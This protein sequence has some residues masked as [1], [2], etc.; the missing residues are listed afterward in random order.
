VEKVCTVPYA[1]RKHIIYMTIIKH[2]QE[3]IEIPLN[4]GDT[5]KFGKFKN[6]S[7]IYKSHYINDKGDM[8]IVTDTGKEISMCKIRLVKK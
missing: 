6:K 7:A 8:I 5:F 2:F 1:E 3:T 4:P